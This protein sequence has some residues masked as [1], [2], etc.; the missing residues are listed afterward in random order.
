MYLWISLLSS[1][2][3][4]ML[5]PQFSFH[6]LLLCLYTQLQLMRSWLGVL[7]DWSCSS[8]RMIRICCRKPV[9]RH[10]QNIHEVSSWRRF[11]KIFVETRLHHYMNWTCPS[12]SKTNSQPIGG[13]RCTATQLSNTI[14]ILHKAESL[15]LSGD[16]VVEGQ[17]VEQE[18]ENSEGDVSAFK[19]S[20]Q[21]QRNNTHCPLWIRSKV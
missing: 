8:C 14:S 1:A 9:Y 17:T 19:E 15:E 10:A 16:E 2:C 11:P 7:L 21:G 6:C 13:W 4:Y 18:G 12:F 3:V 5:K 20:E